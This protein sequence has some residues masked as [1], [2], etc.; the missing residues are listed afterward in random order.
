MKQIVRLTLIGCFL[1]LLAV[2]QPA[3][4]PVRFSRGNFITGDNIA[5]GNFRK[6]SISEALFDHRYYVLLQFQQLPGKKQQADLLQAGIRLETYLP[7]NAYLAVLEENT[8]FSRLA[9]YGIRS[10]NTVPAQYR[11][12]ADLK[13]YRP[14]QDKKNQ[15]M[16]ALQYSRWADPAA[17]RRAVQ[18]T[19]AVIL[20]QK[21][22]NGQLLML[23]YDAAQIPALTR[24]PFVYDIS[25]VQQSDQALNYHTRA[26][27]G[28]GSLN[29]ASGKNLNGAGV[30]I[31]IGD[32]ADISSHLDF[33]G[34][35]INRSPWIPSNHGTHVA[36]TAAGAGIINPKNRGMAA[37]AT[38]VNQ[39]FSDIIVN[40]PV[41]SSDYNMVVTNNSYHSAPNGCAGE[42]GYNVLSVYADAQISSNPSLLHVVAAG[43][44]GDLTCSPFPGGFGTVKSGWQC[45]KNVLT[46]G[47]LNLDNYS[48]ASYSSRG[49][50][51]DGR[52]KPEITANGFAVLSTN[53]NNNYGIN[54]GT[55][56]AAPAV[57]GALTLMHERY[58]QLQGGATPPGALMKALACNTA[59]DLGNAGPDYTY[60]FGMINARRAVEAIDSSRWFIS[61]MTGNGSNTHNFNVPANTR[62]LKVMLYWNDV[63]GAGNAANALVNDIDLVVLTP[64]FGIRRPLI[65]NPDPAGVQTPATEAADHLNNIEQVIIDN[66]A[67]GIYSANINGF[68]LPAGTQDYV[69]T[70]EIITNGVTVLHPAGG[71]TLVPGET[72]TIRWSAAGNENNTFTIEYS[73][74]NGGNWTVLS[75]AVS[76]ASRSFSWTVPASVTAG[77]RIR[78]SRNNSSF[79][80]QSDAPFTI[81]GQPTVT[82]SNACPGSVQLS[83]SAVNGATGYDVLQLT[84]DSMRVVGN[85]TSTSFLL[86]GLPKTTTAWLGVAARLNSTQG[87]RSLSVSILPGSGPCTLA[88]F[89]N[90]L[91]VDTI[92]EPNSARRFFSNAGDVSR[93]VRIRIRNGGNVTVTGPFSVSLTVGTGNTPLVTEPINSSI[94]AG[95]TLTY[96]FTGGFSLL[97]QGGNYPLKVW[98][99]HPADPFRNNDTAYKTVK[100]IPNNPLTSL[101]FRED[102]ESLPA[103]TVTGAEMAAG[104]YAPLDF[105]SSTARGRLR[106]FVNSGMALSGSRAL[107]LDQAP[108]SATA[109]AD[110][111]VFSYNLSGYSNRQLRV[112]FY[113]KNHGQADASGNRVWIRGSENNPW[114]EAYDLFANQ[115]ALGEWSKAMINVNDVL[116]NAVPPQTASAT[117]QMKIGQEGNT[118]A[119][120]VQPEVDIDDGYSFDNLE[121]NEAVNDVSV[122]S[123][124]SPDKSGCGLSAVTP[125]TIRLRNYQNNALSNIQ[126]NY[127]VN[128]GPVVSE[129]IS[130]IGALQTIDY[131]FSQLLNLAAYIDYDISVWAKYSGDSYAS[132]DSILHYQ[133]HNSPVITQYP[134]HE[135]FESDNGNYYTKGTNNSWEWGI[136]ANAIINKAPN[137]SKA[138]I[139]RLNGNYND[140]ETSYLYSPCFNL[141]PYRRWVLSFSHTYDIELDYDY[142]WVEYSTDGKTWT[143]LGTAGAGTNWYDN[144]SLN[145]WSIS[146]TRWHT[147]SYNLPVNLLDPG[148]V[149]M[150][151]RWVM[152]SDGGVTQ[153]GIGID[154]VR[155]HERLDIAGNPAPL[156]PATN[157][158]PWGNNWV[159]F[160]YGDQLMGPWWVLGEINTHGQDLGSVTVTPYLNYLNPVRSSNNEY[161]LDKSFV[162]QSTRQPT[163]P[164]SLRLYFSEQ[165]VVDIINSSECPG[166]VNP[167]DAYVLGVVNYKGGSTEEDGT[168]ANNNDGLYRF[169]TPDSTLILPHNE[170]YYAEFRTS[171]LGEFWFALN[172]T[173]PELPGQCPGDVIRFQIAGSGSAY[174]WQVN[175]G[176]G[177]QDISDGI[178]YNGTNNFILEISGLPTSSTGYRYRCIV[179]GVPD[180]EYTLRFRNYWTGGTSTS[181]FAPGNWSC[182]TVPDQFTDVVIPGGLSR[183]PVL[184]ANAAVR[185]LRVLAGVPLQI[186]NGVQ[187]EVKG[188]V[189]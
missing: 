172:N 161:Y 23:Q 36:G 26:A 115:P 70:Y 106:S 41:Y 141:T 19:G 35:L 80:D 1:N 112:D 135:S 48:I 9:A 127:Q 95:G 40:A 17:V 3:D 4:M 12:D 171:S 132:N 42:G 43:N 110:S 94:A 162:V 16:M 105:R 157:S 76:A 186:N 165:N 178:N 62:R 103:F 169:I 144:F 64:S 46:V 93:P 22:T 15:L 65:L 151:F 145:K 180:V 153:E 159:P 126:V 79:S 31:G 59:D 72:E 138:W 182:G 143:K 147:A 158:G 7:G 177:Y 166:C 133:V 188:R 58:R 6:D 25:L 148:A 99:N 129:T 10:V 134:Y 34:R 73:A 53:A 55:S 29:A 81:L 102:F 87:R 63:A 163:S 139:T 54:Y 164:V 114:V 120:S 39:F 181:W 149:T 56:M 173:A 140:N 119:N 5:R 187:L 125:L 24:L 175:T 69:V 152:S 89:N 51:A 13:Q 101:P 96:T 78:V 121:I 90:D 142:T 100:D 156:F 84:G 124:L 130:S 122:L 47:A 107:T 131:S 104:T 11:A 2:G 27:S 98:V 52:I 18:Q 74:D 168:L 86:T 61:S 88:A 57:T 14:G 28:A 160:A 83:W 82:A 45:A 75:S 85:T 155:V 66:P 150:R 109:N 49:P 68:S 174:Q 179:N 113:Y 77:G 44:D 37:K 117:F 92:L 123:I 21:W 116:G 50:V 170:G 71:E 67:P 189:E 118:S 33:T 91:Q 183:Y 8:D 185:S 136:P 108:Y 146:N 20:T 60:G 128:G 167:A 137:G 32:N 38:L 154:D 184:T 30:V 176:S 111:A 97:P